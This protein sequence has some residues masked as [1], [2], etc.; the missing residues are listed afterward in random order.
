MPAGTADLLIPPPELAEAWR[1]HGTRARSAIAL[2]AEET[3]TETE[4]CYDLTQRLWYA[5]TSFPFFQLP[6]YV[7]M[8]SSRE[9]ELVLAA[10]PDVIALERWL[11]TVVHAL[12]ARALR[13]DPDLPWPPTL[14]QRPGWPWSRVG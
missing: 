13:L 9:P 2:A 5:V 6:V 3:A 7:T 8:D 14:P 1:V 10:P 12:K 4:L 11:W